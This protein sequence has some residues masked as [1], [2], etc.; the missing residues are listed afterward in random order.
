[1]FDKL[2][3]KRKE[4][5]LTVAEMRKHPPSDVYMNL[6]DRRILDWHIANLEYAN[7]TWLNN[8]SLKHWD[9][10]DEFEFAGCHMSGES[11]LSVVF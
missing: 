10:D 7:A 6:L 9:Q 4:L 1:T 5:E 8:L 3:Q 11:A 2:E